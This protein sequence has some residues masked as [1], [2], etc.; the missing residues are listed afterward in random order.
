VI[1]RKIQVI[2]GWYIFKNSLI[3]QRSL[4]Q[5]QAPLLNKNKALESNSKA[6]FY[7]FTT[8]GVTYCLPKKGFLPIKKAVISLA[9]GKSAKN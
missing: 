8:L 7:F 9:S 4:V 1:Y 3:T 5:I 2:T 6:F